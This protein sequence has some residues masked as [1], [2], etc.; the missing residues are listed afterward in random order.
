MGMVTVRAMTDRDLAA[1]AEIEQAT[2]ATPW[3]AAAFA[4]EL[5]GNDCAHYL[6]ADAN[7]QVVGFGGIWIVTDQGHI[8]NIAVQ[9][10]YRGQGVGGLITD[11]LI[12]LAEQ[13][14]VVLMTLE[15]RRSNLAAQRLYAKR[16]FV[17]RGWRRGYYTDTGEDAIIMCREKRGDVIGWIHPGDRN[18][19]R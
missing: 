12:A 15:V 14:G 10:D 6:V 5:H 11:G 17:A 16:G 2:F 19:L 1:V 8:T 3:P 18:I 4:Q 9:E 7:D 13:H